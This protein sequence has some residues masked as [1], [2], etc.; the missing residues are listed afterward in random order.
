MHAPDI[1]AYTCRF[2]SGNCIKVRGRGSAP[3]RCSERRPVG[4][5]LPQRPS[6]DGERERVK[7]ET[8][9]SQQDGGFVSA[10]AAEERQSEERLGRD[11]AEGEVPGACGVHLRLERGGID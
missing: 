10:G 4:I 2:S 1:T 3:L 9:S 8:R 11:A 6:V 5:G 7:G